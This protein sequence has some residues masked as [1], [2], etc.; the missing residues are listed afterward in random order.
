MGLF[1]RG[2][3]SRV[4]VLGLGNPGAEY[5][6]TRHNAG[7]MVAT[8]LAKRID[9]KLKSHRSGCLVAEGRIGDRPVAVARPTSYMNE[10]G[11]PARRLVDFYKSPVEEVIVVH[12]ELD[13]DFGD[14]RIKQGGGTAGHNG[15]RSLA[16]HLGGGF[17][18]VRIGI[19]RPRGGDATSWVLQRF[20]GA[21]R[22]ELPLIL[23]DAADAVELIVGSGIERAMNETNTRT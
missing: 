17:V 2:R 11:G 7:A 21:E 8:I 5:A 16:S 4:V 20:S 19:G 14:I 13:I 1:G 6:E 10:S 3:E 23:E 15:L 12:D 22:K 9:A 18:R